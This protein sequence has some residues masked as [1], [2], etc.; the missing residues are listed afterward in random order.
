M[1]ELTASR[2][3]AESM[4]L[5]REGRGWSQRR[6]AERLNELGLD[7]HQTT[8][9]KW[10]TGKRK[11]T[12]DEA[13]AISSALNVQL[14]HMLAGSYLRGRKPFAVKIAPEV[15]SLAAP[16]MLKWLRGLQALPGSDAWRYMTEVSDEEKLEWIKNR[17]AIG[18]QARKAA[19]Q[20][21]EQ[22]LKEEDDA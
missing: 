22:E 9:G 10:E 2:V 1:E 14:V 18:A 13:L 20:W 3:F 17:A 21:L 19:D 4:R 8:V 7:V 16:S 15:P 11:F 5:Q 6:L 12:L